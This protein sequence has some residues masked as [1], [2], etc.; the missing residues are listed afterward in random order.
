MAATDDVDLS[1]VF[2]KSLSPAL[3]A[4][5]RG[6]MRAPISKADADHMTLADGT[7]APV[8]RN[9]PRFVP[10]DCYAT[11]FSFQWTTYTTTQVDSV[12]GSDL[13]QQDLIKK[14]GLT[15]ADVAGK[16]VLDAGVG[17]GRHTEVLARWGA[18]VVGVDLS[19][20]VESARENLAGYDNAVVLQADIGN[21]PFR[22]EAFDYVISIGVLHHTPDTRT[23]T[24]KLVPL[25]KPGGELAIWVYS[26]AFSR[27]G[28]W[29]PLV[30]R[31][32][33]I[34]FKDWCEWIVDVARAERGNPWLEAF[35]RQFPFS[36]HHPTAERSVL[37]LFDGYSPTY[38]W[39]HTV[40]EVQGWFRDFGLTDIHSSPSPTAVRGHKPASGAI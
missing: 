10:S 20:A 19:D 15:P 1:R 22:P 11:S 35:M 32:P 13:T 37:A 40:E 4:R 12:Q 5:L 9:I 2:G 23:Y 27:R 25:L 30:S 21:L 18:L 6:A 33:L 36:T 7:D 16:L 31:L 38:H 34:S 24:E 14:T 17:V 8:L 39:T 29:V 28:E 3:E 26:Q